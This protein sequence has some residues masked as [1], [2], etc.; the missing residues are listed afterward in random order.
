MNI[1]FDRYV[2]VYRY[3]NFSGSLSID[4]DD[5]DDKSYEWLKIELNF[6]LFMLFGFDKV[7]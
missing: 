7:Y 3:F 1:D 4:D 2:I 5:Y 6:V